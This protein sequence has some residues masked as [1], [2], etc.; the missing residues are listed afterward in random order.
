[1]LLVKTTEFLT[2]YIQF[3]ML[4]DPMPL[5]LLSRFAVT[6]RA[7]AHGGGLSN[8]V[9]GTPASFSISAVKPGLHAS[10]DLAIVI[11]H[12]SINVV[13]MVND[14]GNGQYAVTYTPSTAG[15]CEAAITYKQQHI[16]GSPFRV[17]VTELPNPDKVAVDGLRESDGEYAAGVPV[18][19]SVMTA[20]SGDGKLEVLATAPDGREVSAYQRECG[21]GKVAVRFDTPVAGMYT[22]AILWSG[23]HVPKSPFQVV[24]V[25]ALTAEKIKVGLEFHA[26]AVPV[27]GFTSCQFLTLVDAKCKE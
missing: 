2:E 4:F 27:D 12:K 22:V 17:S 5:T 25:D 19:L 14:N 1:M 23:Q 20:G 8:A 3:T 15:D 21:G 11:K 9:T 10:G 16:A 18:E 24:V 6:P 7:Q 26:L 13:A